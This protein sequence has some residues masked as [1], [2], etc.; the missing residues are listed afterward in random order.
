MQAK[1]SFPP[2]FRIIDD[3][4]YVGS[5][6]VSSHL[7][8]S[9][10]GHV[11]I[12]TCNPGD[13]PS[14]LKSIRDLKFSPND[15]KYILTT[16]GHHDHVGGTK[17]IA[18]ETGAKICVGEADVVAVEKG[19]AT[20]EGLT[21]FATFK[22]DKMLKDGDIIPLGNKEIRVYHTPGHTPGCVS[23]GFKINHEGRTCNVFLFGGAGL[24]VFEERNLK[25][26][27]YGGTLQDFGKT[28]DR[29]ETLKVDV[30]LGS[31][32][33]QND[34][35]GKLDLLLKGI[36][37]NPYIDPSGWKV[38]LKRLRTDLASFQ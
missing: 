13:G 30:W 9:D 16:H 1:D 19:S 4:Y 33:N 14:V 35:F 12:D 36:S 24:N 21:G 3:I 28:L 6:S 8:T 31:H 37:P 15:I 32:P 25:R 22:V 2:A 5:R 17:I 7:I 20:R 18:E 23:I 38:F 10:E 34:T 27:I 11:L 26:G 29:L